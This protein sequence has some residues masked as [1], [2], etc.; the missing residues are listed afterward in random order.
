MSVLGDTL[1]ITKKELLIFIKQPV[2]G[3]TRSLIFPL[4]WIVFFAY[5]FGGTLHSIPLAIVNDASGQYSQAVVNNIDTGNTFDIRFMPYTDALNSFNDG[6]VFAVVY[7]PQ[8]FDANYAAGTA[9]MYLMLDETNPSLYSLIKA[10]VE[11]SVQVVSQAVTRPQTPAINLDEEVF[12]GKETRYI[13]FLAPGIV[14]QTIIFSAMFSGGISLLMDKEFGT[15]KLLMLAPISRTSIV[16]GK[17]LGGVIQALIAGFV[18]LLVIIA[19]GAHVDYS[20][21]F[22]LAAPV[23]MTLIAF[24]FIGMSTLIATRIK[25]LEQFVLVMQ[26]VIQPLWFVSG[27]IYPI[28]SMPDWMQAFA[29]VNPMTYAVDGMRSVMVRGGT[30]MPIIPDLMVL[31]AFSVIIMLVGI[32]SFRRIV[33]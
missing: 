14:I 3:I 31:I 5:G 32:R 21:A 25:S 22:F 28:Y 6:K 4:V 15:L 12:Y 13:D 23:I 1:T 30:L 29:A 10:G 33:E 7:I 2:F 19:A 18:T 24:A 8:D 9:K 26:L 11:S 16:L 20:I 27:A 17:T